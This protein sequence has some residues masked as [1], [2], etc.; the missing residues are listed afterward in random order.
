MN[1]DITQ[2]GEADRA[3]LAALLQKLQPS[4]ADPVEKRPRRKRSDI[5]YLTEDEIERFFRAVDAPR[6]RAL[7]RLAYHRGLRA[8]E[9]GRLQLADWLQRDDRLTVR[10]LK[11]SAG[12]EYHL[13]KSEVTALRAWLRVRGAEPGPLFVSRVGKGISQ[14]M[15]DLLMKRYGAAAGLPR[16][17]CHMHSLKH[18]CGTHLLN[19]GE[20]IEDVKDHLG[21]RNIQNTLVYAQ[22]TNKRR[23]ERDRRLRD[24]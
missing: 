23:H 7:F 15:L 8:R 11:G 9:I 14:Q 3:Q 17:K 13:T 20:S 4:A 12:G 1:L 24:W 10:R 5:K 18:S 19:R 21:H 22:Y 16:E 6:D 2:L